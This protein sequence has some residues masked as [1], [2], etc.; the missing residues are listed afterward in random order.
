M[1]EVTL[2]LTFD[3]NS[4]IISISG[5]RAEDVRIDY[6]ADIDFTPLV[7][8]LLD[9]IATDN[10][11]ILQHTSTETHDEKDK[12]VEKTITEIIA[13]YNEIVVAAPEEEAGGVSP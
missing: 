11:F 7:E 8:S 6:S 2:S 12:L 10:S 5:L 3:E 1:P 9:G 13:K 4:K